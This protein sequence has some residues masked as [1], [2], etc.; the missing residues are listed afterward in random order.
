MSQELSLDGRALQAERGRLGLTVDQAA[1]SLGL[2]PHVYEGLEKGT[3][4]LSR[5]Q[6]TRVVLLLAMRNNPAPAQAGASSEQVSRYIP[7]A[8]RP[9]MPAAV[10]AAAE[11]LTSEADRRG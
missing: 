1:E 8:A 6:A 5:R 2:E 10:H 7:G 4:K 9:P 3:R 11:L